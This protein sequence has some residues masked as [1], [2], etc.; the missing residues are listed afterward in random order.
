[1]KEIFVD[2][3]NLLG[4]ACWV[5]IITVQPRCIY[6]FGPFLNKKEAKMAQP[7]YIEDLQNEG[8]IGITVKIK[9]CKPSKLTICDERQEQKEIDIIPPP[10]Q[11]SF[12]PSSP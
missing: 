11:S 12:L 2:N 6:Y 7:G 4:L 5:E 8:A 1:M 9:Y 10:E 3:L